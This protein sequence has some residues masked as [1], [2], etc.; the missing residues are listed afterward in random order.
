M[1]NQLYQMLLCNRNTEIQAEHSGTLC[2]EETENKMR[3]K[4]DMSFIT[5]VIPRP[6]AAAAGRLAFSGLPR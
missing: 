2:R 4:L 3:L 1:D 5:K 6:N